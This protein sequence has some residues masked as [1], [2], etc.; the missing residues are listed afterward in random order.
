MKLGT[1]ITIDNRLATVVDSCPGK[2]RSDHY[3][4]GYQI[5]RFADGTEKRVNDWSGKPDGLPRWPR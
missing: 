2:R 5:V 3:E 4:P 1:T